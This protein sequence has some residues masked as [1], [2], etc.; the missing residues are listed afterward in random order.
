M[1]IDRPAG[2]RGHGAHG[3][4]DSRHTFSFA[5]YYDPAWM[6]FGPL[7]VIN[8][9]RVQ[10]G[11]GFPTHHHANMEIV[12][13]VLAGA[14]AH[15]DSTGAEDVL[16]VDDVQ[17]MSAGAGID[18]SEYNGS[19]SEPVHF[20]QVW[21]QP[22]RVNAPPMHAQR[23][24]DPGQADGRWQLLVAPGGDGGALPIRQAARILRGRP[25]QDALPFTVAADRR[26]WLQV[27]GGQVEVAG[28]VLGAGDAIGIVD[29]A[30][31]FSVRGTDPDALVILFD[32]PR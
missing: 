28:R 3:W 31:G 29:E 12:S 5:D 6:G 10:P 14:L 26:A 9:D 30:A 20:L 1:I 13:I 27:A 24:F 21:I 17:C 15:R 32:L 4:L 2:T 18:H 19:A 7:R 16:H 11:H 23:R 25:G 8:E 22:D